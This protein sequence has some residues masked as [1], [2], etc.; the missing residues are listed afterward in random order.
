MNYLKILSIWLVMWACDVVPWVSGGTI[1][2]ISGIYEKLLESIRACTQ[3]STLK[4]LFRWEFVRVR[5]IINWTFLFVLF[6]GIGGSILL[7]SQ[8]L[9]GFLDTDPHLVWAFFGGLVVSSIFLLIQKQKW[10]TMQQVF[11]LL[12]WVVFAYTLTH[13]SPTQ[14]IPHR[15]MIILSASIAICAMILPGISGSFILLVLWMYSHV[16]AALSEWNVAFLS[17]FILWMV[18]WLM[19]FVHVVTYF[20]HTHYNTTIS[21]LIWFMI[22]ALPKLRPRQNSVETTLDRHWDELILQAKSVLPSNYI[23]EPQ[24]TLVVI[25]FFV[26]L[27][28]S[29]LVL[30]H[31]HQSWQK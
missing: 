20:L 10:R 2:F 12:L 21:V 16:I 23:W 4:Y 26:W 1:A 29:L 27:F 8:L 24:L 13:L 7:F 17:L 15:R 5:N 22:G 18:L 31:M 6:L 30:Q 19:S 14:V 25:L 28:G 3:L 11:W 9:H